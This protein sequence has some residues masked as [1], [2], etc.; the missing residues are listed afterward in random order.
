[1]LTPAVL[2]VIALAQPRTSVPA[3]DPDEALRT[4]A[5]VS[6]FQSSASHADVLAFLSTLA[7]HAQDVSRLATFGQSFENRDLP[8]LI[9]SDPPVDEPHAAAVLSEREG[10]PI[11]LLFGNIH[12]GEVDAKDALLLL[13]RELAL[14]P[15]KPLLKSVVVLIA[16]I[17]NA[18][19]N[20]RLGPCHTIRSQQ[21]G[22]PLVGQRH[23][24]QDLDLNR[25]WVKLESP[26][27]R[28]F[29]ALLNA[30]NP[31]VIVDGHTTDGSYT[32]YLV[33]HQGPKAPAG[34]PRL[35]AFVNDSMLPEITRTLR[36]RSDIDMFPYG[37]F[38]GS[39]DAPPRLHTTWSTPPA[40]PRYSTHYFGLRG[41]IGILSESYSH[42][43]FK[44]R[45][46]G[47]LEFFREILRYAASHRH[48]IL[49]RCEDADD[50]GAGRTPASKHVPLRANP[51]PTPEKALV[52]G[53]RE[54]TRD[55]K[56]V[57]TSEPRDYECTVL[58]RVETTLSVPRPAAYVLLFPI[59]NAA[60]TL[61]LHG[62]ST[63]ALDQPAS[64]DVERYTITSL[65]R[66]D[67]PFQGH[68][69]LSNVEVSKS[70]ERITLPLGTLYIPTDQPLGALACYL[71]EP[72]S[73]DGLTAWNFFDDWMKPAGAFPV[74]RVLTPLPPAHH[75]DK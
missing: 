21:D 28:A 34:D 52:K 59:P 4:P 62:I 43:P 53:Y 58:S 63:L 17:Y 22:P 54:E 35:N 69:L 37:D 10:R 15:E 30:W 5:E 41:R 44:D 39:H 51:A 7:D 42:S 24:A 38:E 74:A 23:N 2:A 66:A 70:R 9:L 16:P 47:S 67:T 14:G 56:S 31:H 29:V 25:D 60:Y 27:A 8:L 72:Q 49:K 40:L 65:T 18:D 36:E 75:D 1:M 48:D 57:P 61:S 71:L 45:V 6:S 55:G 50:H 64:L 73:D 12:A 32:R 20:E 33:T 46:L 26:E 13:A 3:P 68:R 11:V 19:G